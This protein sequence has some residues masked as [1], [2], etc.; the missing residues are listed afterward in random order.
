M[1]PLV[2]NQILELGL[3]EIVRHSGNRKAENEQCHRNRED[4]VAESIETPVRGGF[5][6]GEV[7]DA[8]LC[9]QVELHPEPLVS[10]IYEAEGMAAKAMHVAV[11][12][13]YTAVAHDDGDLVQR[14][15]Q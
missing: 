12:I 9:F 10:S 11:G 13:A 3:P 1:R 7:A 2:K 15:G 4:I 8:L 6:I 14:L 5:L